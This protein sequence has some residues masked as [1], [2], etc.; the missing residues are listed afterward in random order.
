MIIQQYGPLTK[1]VRK[2]NPP[3]Y[4][5]LLQLKPF[6]KP[7]HYCNHG[8]AIFMGNSSPWFCVI[9]FSWTHLEGLDGVRAAPAG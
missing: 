4:C 5:P 3:Q 8:L 1:E 7:L 6:L 9:N 2:L